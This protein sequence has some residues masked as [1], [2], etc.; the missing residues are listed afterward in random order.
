MFGSNA[1]GALLRRSGV[2]GRAL[3]SDS[4]LLLLHHGI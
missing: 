3:D 4:H 1:I 2:V